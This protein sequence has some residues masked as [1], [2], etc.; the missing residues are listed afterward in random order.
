MAHIMGPASFD[1]SLPAPD[2]GHRE[3]GPVIGWRKAAGSG[4][5]QRDIKTS[6]S[7]HFEAV[8]TK[9][10]SRQKR[11]RPGTGGSDG[12][13]SDEDTWGD[14]FGPF[15]SAGA[16]NGSGLP[17]WG[18]SGSGK[19][20]GSGSG[21]NGWPRYFSSW[22]GGYS[23]GAYPMDRAIYECL[24]SGACR[25]GIY[26]EAHAFTH[27]LRPPSLTHHHP[28]R[29]PSPSLTYHYPCLHPLPVAREQSLQI[30]GPM[31]FM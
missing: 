3:Q 5:K 16:G 2:R 13:S 6:A 25:E 14:W 28:C 1:C 22:D 26:S 12:S 4:R 30:K 31:L 20:S 23:E 18:G 15:D 24:C 11:G 8:A 7:R 29:H 21:N 19:G 27:Y 17:P 10:R 9:S